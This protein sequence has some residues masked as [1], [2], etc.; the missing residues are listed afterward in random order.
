M[1]QRTIA[2]LALLS[3]IPLGSARDAEGAEGFADISPLSSDRPELPAPDGARPGALPLVLFDP[4]LA[5]PVPPDQLRAE[6]VSVFREL[7]V[8]VTWREGRESP[9]TEGPDLQ[10][11]VLPSDRSGGRLSANTMGAVRRAED[12]PRAL[13]VFLPAVRAALGLP[14]RADSLLSAADGAA[15]ARALARVIAHETIHA[16]APDHP[17]SRHGLMASRMDRSELLSTRVRIDEASRSA[18]F[19]GL[20]AWM[21]GRPKPRTPAPEILALRRP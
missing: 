18:L 6:V 9:V 21:D 3:V 19:T 5:L 8:A 10:V 15:L 11:I 7:G 4:A 20:D 12:A 1:V 2:V 13:W 16:V 17:H 14:A